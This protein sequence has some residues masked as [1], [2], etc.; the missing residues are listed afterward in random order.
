MEKSYRVTVDYL[1]EMPRIT[2]EIGL[3]T[4]D[5]P[6]YTTFCDWFGEIK[7]RAIRLLLRLSSSDENERRVA[8]DSTGFD[9]DR[10]SHHYCQRANYRVR[11]LKVTVLVDVETLHVV[12]VHCTTTK[13]HDTQIGEQVIKRNADDLLSLSGDKGYD[14]KKL[15]D[16]LRSSGV[17]PLIRHREFT[18]LDKAHNSRMNND[19]YNQRWMSETAFSSIKRTLG[20]GL[21]SRLWYRE[22]REM[23][24]K[25][26][27]YNI[28]NSVKT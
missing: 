19:D 8:I 17:R 5:L 26:A 9:R 6:H 24:L 1:K 15:R 23:I 28:K 3:D 12:D 27:V 13:K 16:E 25:A 11:S 20:D 2:G 10:A 22:F 14:W 7:I 4:T 18:H 21:R